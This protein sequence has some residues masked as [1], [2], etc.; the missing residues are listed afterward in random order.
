MST[1]AATPSQLTPMQVITLL[2]TW[3]DTLKSNQSVYKLLCMIIGQ[4]R[5]NVTVTD[6]VDIES[7][8]LAVIK[9]YIATKNVDQLGNALVGITL[10]KIL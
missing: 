10:Y 9:N 1:H 5:T 3:S 8:I 4:L 6:L 7:E 2:E